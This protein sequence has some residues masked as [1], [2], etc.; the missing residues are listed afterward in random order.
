MSRVICGK[1]TRPGQPPIEVSLI[2]D[3]AGGFLVCLCGRLSLERTRRVLPRHAEVIEL[4]DG[5]VV[6]FVHLAAK[7]L[8]PLL[9]RLQG[10]PYHVG[11][12]RSPKAW[13]ADL[14]A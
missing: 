7:D 8:R 3:A 14:R 6:G 9:E 1:K 10:S 5:R 4:E 13:A 11:F 2:E 12:S